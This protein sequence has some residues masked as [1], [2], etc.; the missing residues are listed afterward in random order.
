M[1]AATPVIVIGGPTASGKSALALALAERLGG[2]VINADSMQLYRALSIVT[3]RPGEAALARAPHR[4]FGIAEADDPWSAG[5]WQRCA[6]AEIE[7]AHGE[8][9]VPIVVGGTG[10]YLEALVDGLAAVPP[11]DPAIRERLRALLAER[12]SAAMHDLLA[13]RDPEGARAIRAS[14]PQRILRA[15]EVVEATGEPLHEWHARQASPPA[16]GWAV[17]QILLMPGRD[18]VYAACEAR[19]D[20]MIAEGAVEEARAIRAMALDPA[21]P[22]MKAVGLAPLLAHCAGTLTLDEA[23]DAAK[24]DT[25]RYARR[26]MTWFRNRS[27]PDRVVRE[28]YS[29]SLVPEI[30]SFI[31]DF[32]LT[33]TR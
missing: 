33:P 24:R 30:F 8:G 9:L 28:Q 32:R 5:R 1:P 19:F 21:L 20:R 18:A 6:A 29:E 16:D 14:D 17:L 23:V 3:A 7:A 13:E 22:V 25:R 27:R 12:G 2:V 15:L 11:A 31:S 4:L 26:Q 10:L